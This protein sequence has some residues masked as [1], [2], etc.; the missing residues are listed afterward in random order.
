MR[1][2]ATGASHASGEGGEDE[3]DEKDVPE[4]VDGVIA[5]LMMSLQDKV[6]SSAVQ[7]RTGI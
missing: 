1:H 2:A 6:S 7:C 5:R 3:D 4:E